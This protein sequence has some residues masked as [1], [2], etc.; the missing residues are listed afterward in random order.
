MLN[1]SKELILSSPEYSAS[2]ETCQLIG[3]TMNG[4]NDPNFKRIHHY[5]HHIALAIKEIMGDKC[6]VY[7]EIGTHF[8]H[9]LCTILQSKF[10][11]KYISMDLFQVAKTIAPDCKIKDVHKLALSNAEKFNVNNYNVKILKGNSQIQK[12]LGKVKEFAPEGIDLLF[13]DG[14]HS[15][16]GVVKDFE[17]Y[18]PFVNKGGIIIFDDY[19]PYKH[20][21]KDRQCPKA[22]DYLVNKYKNDLNIIGL[23]DDQAGANKLK[24]KNLSLNI[25]YIVQKK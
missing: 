3:T 13:I 5:N 21:G 12:S 23:V 19:L 2:L 9:S 6:K 22:V 25:D 8:G 15:Y 4:H 17:L 11:S 20:A 10:N 16:K 18:F 1:I 24:N 14:D 7:C